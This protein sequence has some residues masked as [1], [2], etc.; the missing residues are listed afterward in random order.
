MCPLQQYLGVYLL[1]VVGSMSVRHVQARMCFQCDGML[2]SA[3]CGIGFNNEELLNNNHTT[4][5]DGQC[6]TMKIGASNVVRGC[7]SD[8]ATTPGCFYETNVGSGEKVLVCN[9]VCDT[10]YCNG[11]D[12]ISAPKPLST[13]R[14]FECQ[15]DY[16]TSPCG[17]SF[18]NDVMINPNSTT[19]CNGKC[20]ATTIRFTNVSR[21]CQLS[22]SS[23]YGCYYDVD[24]TT[25]KE[26]FL[27]NNICDTDY[28]NGEG[29]LPEKNPSRPTPYTVSTTAPRSTPPTTAVICCRACR[30]SDVWNSFVAFVAMTG[31]LYRQLI[32]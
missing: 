1:L 25:G 30:R 19:T 29:V 22:N 5:C 12:V 24:V 31:V 14:C 17:I 27:C 13:R 6:L 3:S 10:D 8:N 28:C 7:L 15:G 23:R 20:I 21:G 16:D 18:R 9:H 32:S 11:A 2:D 26:V 4:Y